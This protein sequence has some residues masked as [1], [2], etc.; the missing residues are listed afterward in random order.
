MGLIDDARDSLI[1]RIWSTEHAKG[2]YGTIVLTTTTIRWKKDYKMVLY[3]SLVK[4]ILF[5]LIFWWST[6]P[7]YNI[8]SPVKKDVIFYDQTMY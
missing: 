8:T 3:Y 7:T 1:G 4:K 6:L 5:T 2:N